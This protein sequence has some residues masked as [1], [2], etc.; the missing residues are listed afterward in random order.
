MKPIHILLFILSVLSLLLLIS[1]VFPKN[2]FQIN[3]KMK[4]HF[5]SLEELIKEDTVSYAD[6]SDIISQS[7]AIH[8]SMFYE[9]LLAYNDPTPIFQDTVRADEDSLKIKLHK[10]EF[11]DR[12]S[13]ILWPF[14][15]HLR[16]LSS[17]GSL[18][19]IMHYGDSQ[20]EGD[21][22]T[23]F[24]RYRLQKRFGGSGVGLKPAVQLYGY[25]L[26]LKHT[27]SD[28]WLRYTAF[29]NVDSTLEHNRYGAL[30]TFARFTEYPVDSIEID[31]TEH[32]AWISFQRS[33]RNYYLS[34]IFKECKLYFMNTNNPVWLE[35]YA[36]DELY[37]A[38]YLPIDD[39]LQIKKWNFKDTPEELMFKFKSQIS[40]DFYGIAMDHTHGIAVDNIPMRG[41][42]GLVFT[43][44]DRD[45]LGS[46]YDSLNVKL[47]ILQFGGNV[48]PYIAEGYTYY[49]RWFF[50]QLKRLKAVAP[51]VPIVVIGV[52]DMSIKEKD[53]YVTYPNLEAI[54]DALKNATFRAG[55]VYWDMYEAMG[56][57]NSMPSWVYA[58]PPL[59]AKDFVHFN[60]RGARVIAE[61]FYNAFIYEYDTYLRSLNKQNVLP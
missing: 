12:D 39:H 30:G 50:S 54:R 18:I 49:E 19:R 10:L 2:G 38:D 9:D 35:L 34:G 15:K 57:C 31:S 25:Q 7:Y 56:G 37:E 4:L 5:V 36:D 8:D 13:S 33:E 40:P 47:L 48:V 28:N 22:M 58:Q 3:D 55:C 51:N 17:S 32:E 42:A 44:M 1:I 6:I 43:K 11:P 41:S 16:K 46:M 14:F 23:S 27:A 21:R 53:K 26:S 52:S 60:A 61:M 45:L 20:I 24:I 29:G 59:A